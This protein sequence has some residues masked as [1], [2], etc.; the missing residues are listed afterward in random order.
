MVEAITRD[1]VR[2]LAVVGTR[3]MRARKG[4]RVT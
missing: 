2:M 4:N 1:A 3:T